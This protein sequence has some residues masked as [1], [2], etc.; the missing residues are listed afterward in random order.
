MT[1]LTRSE[2]STFGL[3]MALCVA[4]CS[5]IWSDDDAPGDSP[6]AVLPSE[7][8]TDPTDL[9]PGE[10][11]AASEPAAGD[12][13]PAEPEAAEEPEDDG[14]SDEEFLAD[15]FSYLEGD[16]QSASVDLKDGRTRPPAEIT[17]P[18]I[19]S[20][21]DL[22]IAELEKSG[23]GG[24]NGGGPRP[25]EQSTL[26]PGPGGR[27]EMHAP[28]DDG[29]D[30]AELTPKEREKILQS[31]T[32]GFPPGFDAVLADYFRRV[33]RGRESST[34]TDAEATSDSDK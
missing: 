5:M 1:R 3:A 17:Q 27:G 30:W 19:L 14:V 15:P 32:D 31:R 34:A 12:T 11:D 2:F 25:A 33:A 4:M 24:G 22:M 8:D 13:S 18:R 21:L 10:T 6:P 28:N 23:M 26:K 16:M 20:R 9:P 29:R 7:L